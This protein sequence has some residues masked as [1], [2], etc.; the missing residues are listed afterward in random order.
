MSL[1]TSASLRYVIPQW[2]ISLICA[3]LQRD[4]NIFVDIAFFRTE[5]TGETYLTRRIA[6]N[7]KKLIILIGKDYRIHYQIIQFLL[8]IHFFTTGSRYHHHAHERLGLKSTYNNTAS[9]DSSQHPI[10]RYCPLQYAVATH[11]LSFFAHSHDTESHHL[12]ILSALTIYNIWY[13][14][15]NDRSRNNTSHPTSTHKK[16]VIGR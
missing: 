10:K 8:A 14:Y 13:I 12:S 16:S 7:I 5:E 3:N 15:N 4:D 6:T 11:S 9:P 2:T 1:V